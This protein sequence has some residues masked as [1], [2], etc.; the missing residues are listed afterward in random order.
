MQKGSF[1]AVALSVVAITAGVFTYAMPA[2]A[3]HSEGKNFSFKIAREG[4]ERRGEDEDREEREVRKIVKWTTSC[5]T[6]TNT[7]MAVD[8]V[9]TYS[10]VVTVLNAYNAQV[11][12]IVASNTTTQSGL[13]AGELALLNVLRGKRSSVPNTL[14]GRGNDV[15]SQIQTLLGVVQPLGNG[16]IAPQIRKPLV[17]ALRDIANQINKLG[18][19]TCKRVPVFSQPNPPVTTNTTT[20]SQTQTQT[21][22]TYTMAQVTAA[23]NPQNCLTVISGGVYNLSS[24]IS[25]HPGGSQAIL[26]ICGKDGTTAFMNQHGGQGNP[27][28]VLTG[29]KVG[30]LQ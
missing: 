24:W 29:F 20:Q 27:M 1:T 23:N 19:L 21:Q 30:V 16:S 2:F 26:S 3:Q 7:I 14:G 25:Q 8:S 28:N 11:Q 18:K 13:S 9:K 6:P 22:T 15:K 17:N 12:T 5:I 10:D 4:G